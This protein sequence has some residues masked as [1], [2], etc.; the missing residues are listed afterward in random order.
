MAVSALRSP[1]DRRESAS[2]QF[3][4]QPLEG[5]SSVVVGTRCKS[6]IDVGTAVFGLQRYQLGICRLAPQETR[7]GISLRYVGASEC[8]IE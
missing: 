2:R 5:L 8:N 1:H 6:A 3:L 7:L 4:S